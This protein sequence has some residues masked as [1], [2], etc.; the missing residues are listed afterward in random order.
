MSDTPKSYPERWREAVGRDATLTI[1]VIN[2][3][4]FS[5]I[6][7]GS[8][9][10]GEDAEADWVLVHYEGWVHGAYQYEQLDTRGKWE[11]AIRHAAGRA[12]TQY[13]TV[14]RQLVP[15]RDLTA[16]GSFHAATDQIEITNETEVARWLS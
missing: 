13:P 2:D 4:A 5:A 8:G 6:K 9:I 14:A 12:L 15:A 16:V 11:A 10:V 1:Y 3:G 7:R